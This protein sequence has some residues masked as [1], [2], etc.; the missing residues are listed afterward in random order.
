MSFFDM[1][2]SL[3][4]EMKYD[5]TRNGSIKIFTKSGGIA[6]SQSAPLLGKTVSAKKYQKSGNKKCIV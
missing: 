5:L 6:K 3:H 4:T 1:P 2:D